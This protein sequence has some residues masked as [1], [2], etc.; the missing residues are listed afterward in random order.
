MCSSDL[1]SNRKIGD[2]CHAGELF[3]FASKSETQGI[4][5]IE[6]MAAGTPVLAVR[7]TGTEDVVADGVNGYMTEDS[8]EE[9]ASK[10]M[11]ILEKKEL[12]L[13]T[14]GAVSTARAYEDGQI[15]L[16]AE[17]IYE[18]AVKI[19]EEK[20]REKYYHRKKRRNMLYSHG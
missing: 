3:L 11:D 14:R 10:L 7:A 4:V 13:L 19:R 15:A 5:L 12:E 16:R 20:L 1:V 9:F 18:E 17:G 6:A 2:Y 8:E